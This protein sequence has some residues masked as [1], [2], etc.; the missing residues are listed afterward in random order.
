[1][2]KDRGYYLKTK[3]LLQDGAV[4]PT[5]IKPIHIFAITEVKSLFLISMEMV[6]YI[7]CIWIYFKLYL[8]IYF[9]QKVEGIFKIQ[10]K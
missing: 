10:K 1:M 7:E 6:Q 3:S 9:E 5:L 4:L 2:L 8:R